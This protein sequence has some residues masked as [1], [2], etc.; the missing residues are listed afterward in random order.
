MKYQ[1]LAAFEKHLHQAAK[2]HLSRVFLIVS[3]CSYERKK[4]YEKILAAVRMKELDLALSMEEALEGD[5]EERIS[6]LNTSSL[7]GGTQILYLDGIDK[8]KKN[9]LA[10]LSGYIA[11]PS[12]FAYLVLG[13]NATK[14]LSDLYTQGKK[15]L[16]VCDLSE[17][18]PWDRKERLKRFL[19]DEAAKAG[20]R[21]QGE[22]VEHLLENVGLQMSSLDQELAKL[23]A[24]CGE[25]GELTLKDVRLLC[26]AEKN[27]TLWQLAEAIVWSEEPPRIDKAADLSLLLPLVSLLRQQLQ[28]G[29]VLS[30]LLE[31]G[32]AHA[33]ISHHLPTLKASALDKML[34]AARGRTSAFFRKALDLLF[35]IELMAKN[36][37]FEPSFILDL[38]IAKITFLKQKYVVSL[39]QSSRRA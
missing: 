32:A 1:N 9:G 5:L 29:M 24:Y 11:H 14:N 38:F 21:W 36:S 12:P 7:L 2:V 39:S 23:L 34:P 22:A 33:E 10:L 3:S 15:E 35:E 31:R 6:G 18:K 20:K 28:Q 17:E 25:R 16:I 26:S 13:A 19:I 4:I 27:S 37:S 8:L 30:I